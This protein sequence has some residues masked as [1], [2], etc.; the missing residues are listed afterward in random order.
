MRS[1]SP[2][3]AGAEHPMSTDE[4]TPRPPKGRFNLWLYLGLIVAAAAMVVA[5]R[6]A[7]DPARKWAGRIEQ[8]H[9]TVMERPLSR[10]FGTADPAAIRRIADGMHRGPMPTPLKDCHRGPGAELLVSPNSFVEF[11]QNPPQSVVSLRDRERN[12]LFRLVGS[13]RLL[14]QALAEAAGNPNDQQRERLTQ[15]IESLAAELAAERRAVQDLV[16]AAR[17]AAS[18]I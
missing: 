10:C 17:G 2:R 18:P 16:N 13:Y 15:R 8:A 9:V 5:W 14:E 12:A 11:L 6:R 4:E 3:R 7:Q 1:L